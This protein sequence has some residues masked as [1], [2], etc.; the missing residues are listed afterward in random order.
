MRWQK[1]AKQQAE[2]SLSLP[3][4]SDMT[5][6]L[7]AASY[8]LASAS[9]VGV[10]LKIFV[11]L[12]HVR[13]NLGLI[14]R[15]NSCVKLMQSIF[16][17]VN[18]S[19]MSFARIYLKISLNTRSLYSV[20]HLSPTVMMCVTPQPSISLRNYK[21]QVHKLLFMIPR[22]SNL[23]VSVSQILIIRKKLLMLLRVRMRSCT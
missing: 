2:M 18:A 11:H 21:Q 17:H 1:S 15:S 12:W 19:S 9:V 13:K 16:V 6:A 5:H 4:Q 20:P 3:R 22:A 8:K 23:H 10:F 14:K 7:V